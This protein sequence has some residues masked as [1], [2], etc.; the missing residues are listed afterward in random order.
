MTTHK[1]HGHIGDGT[2]ID[3]AFVNRLADEAERCYSPSNSSTVSSGN[4]QLLGD[5]R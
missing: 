3:D 5:R 4:G 1:T 2:P